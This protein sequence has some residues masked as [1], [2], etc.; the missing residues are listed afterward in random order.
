MMEKSSSIY[1]YAS[2]VH[3]IN[4]NRAAGM[5]GREA[6]KQAI[7]MCINENIMADYLLKNASEVE[8]MLYSEW[9]MDEALEYAEQ[10]GEK[11]GKEYGKMEEREALIRKFSKVLT[12]EEIATTLEVPL[13]YV[14]QILRND[15]CVCEPTVP[16]K[17][18]NQS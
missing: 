1:E 12:S 10:K 4:S 13:E 14:L 17:N 7:K 2:F 15:M 11:R 6:A 3:R 8:N 5:D 18:S 16:Y 9:N